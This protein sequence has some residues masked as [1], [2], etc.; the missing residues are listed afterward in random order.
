MKTLAF[1]RR[2]APPMA[3]VRQRLDSSQVEDV[4]GTVR[5]QLLDRGL[6]TR[7]KR[8]DR[9]AITAGSRGMGGFIHLLQGTCD[10][11]RSVG[12]EPFLIPAM[13]SHGGATAEGQTELLRRLGVTEEIAPI[14]ASMETLELGTS[15]SGAV[16]HLDRW[17]HEADGV[18]VLGRTKTHPE[19]IEGIASGLL[20]MT[21]VGLGKQAGA[22]QAH[23]SGLWDSVRAV[24]QLT[25]ARAKVIFGITMVENAFHEPTLIE[26]VEPTYEAFLEADQRLLRL[27]RVHLAKIPF[28][29]LD[30]LI[31]DEMGKEISGTGMDVNVIGKWRTHGGERK[32]NYRRIV[33]LSLT[34]ASL[35]NAIGVG[36]ADFI[37]ERFMREYDPATT[38]INILTASEPDCMNTLEAGMPL[39]LPTDRDAIEVALYSAVVQ[40]EPKVCRIKNT[41]RLDELWVSPA[42]LPEV[43]RHPDLTVLDPPEAI[44]FDPNGDLLPR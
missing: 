11:I 13:G 38:Y 17:A 6:A 15:S 26:V 34:Y 12:G 28:D 42:L 43:E 18:I 31:V 5:Q 35:G 44:P 20:K 27:A 23:S 24:P 10:A 30:L 4:R 41:A 33:P 9:I 19:S 2:S 22:Q 39:A 25:L 36:L 14:K 40:G 29:D 3:R 21:T 7:V 32:P 1:P 37:T 16:A 8:G